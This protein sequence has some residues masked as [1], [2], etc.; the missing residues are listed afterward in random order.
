MG[1]RQSYIAI[2]SL[3]SFGREISVTC[4]VQIEIRVSVDTAPKILGSDTL[5]DT[6]DN[7]HPAVT[8]SLNAAKWHCKDEAE[9]GKNCSSLHKQLWKCHFSSC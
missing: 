7:F 9:E 8:E 6:V 2:S 4:P 3:Q 1:G 5:D